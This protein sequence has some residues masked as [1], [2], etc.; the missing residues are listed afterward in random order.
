MEADIVIRG[1]QVVTA[2]A[3]FIAD[4]AIAG[5]KIVAV[6]AAPAAKRT[7]DAAGKYVIPGAIDSH[8]HF[9]AP[10]YDYKEDWQ[11]GTG[12]AARGG[13]TTVL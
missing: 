3:V 13:V 1:G 6:G 2:D 4:V 8:V 5:E 10:G 9:R 11:T 12:A 7:I